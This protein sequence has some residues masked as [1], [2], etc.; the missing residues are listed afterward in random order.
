MLDPFPPPRWLQDL[1]TPWAASLHLYSLPYHI[2]E[3]ILAFAFYQLIHSYL[4]PRL[5]R[6]FF[7]RLYSEL[8]PRTQLNWDIHVVSLVQSVLVNAVALWVTFADTERKEMTVYERIHGYTGALGLVQALAAG[9]FLY[10]IIVSIV[11]IK[12]FGLGM[13]FHGLSAFCVYILGFRPFVNF[14]APTFILYELSSPF[15][16]IHWFLDKLKMTGSK[17]QWYNGMTLLVVFFSCRL[18]WGTWQSFVVYA[19]MWHALKHYR[20][21]STSP[22][23][24]GVE[25]NAPIFEVRDG[26]LC[27]NE[28]CLQANAEIARFANYYIEEG[29]PQWLPMVYVAANLVLNFLNYY[30]FSQ[31]IDAVMKRFREPAAKEDKIKPPQGSDLVLDAAEKLRQEEGYCETGDG[32]EQALLSTG[33]QAAEGDALNKR[34]S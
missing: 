26:A 11:H 10:D 9:Y 2:H 3:V 4:S 29:L 30:W 32:A 19:D 13:V 24:K 27:T 7:P 16:N 22:F 31:M 28:S 14:Y 23:L 12:L 34:R 6:A 25:T 20:S 17:L 21:S 5:S 8:P 15:L 18:V 1:T 33:V